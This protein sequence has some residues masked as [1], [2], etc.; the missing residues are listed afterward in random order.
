M[1]CQLCGKKIGP[2]RRM[3]DGE[4][5][6]AAHRQEARTDLDYSLSD[7]DEGFDDSWV[8]AKSR[9]AALT[10]A[11]NPSAQAASVLLLVMAAVLILATLSFSN[12]SATTLA[13]AA[14]STKPADTA[15]WF[16]GV[17]SSIGNTI[18][19]QTPATVHE[20]FSQGLR[21]WVKAGARGTD[22]LRADLG[23]GEWTFTAAGLKPGRLRIWKRSAALANYEVDFMAQ[24]DHKSMGWAYR[25]TD[26]GNFYGTKLSILRPGPGP[27][28]SLTRFIMM[29]G[30]ET[31][32]VQ[33]PLPITLSAGETC[34]VRLSV[35]GD[36]FLTSVNGQVISFWSDQRF[37]RGGVGFFNEEGESAT[38]KW[39]NLSERDS[40]LGQVLSYFSLLRMPVIE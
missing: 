36:R 28:A 23:S 5:C 40:L 9:R 21:E 37:R 6:S 12:G 22:S 31:E 32:R 25:A 13:I 4:F 11:G 20:D 19:R 18:R 2:F 8:V 1:L 35:R 16:S 15:S 29:N 34:R 7:I 39:V 3:V 38:L 17:G 14:P 24:I 10:R 30:K 26:A 33:M 27:N